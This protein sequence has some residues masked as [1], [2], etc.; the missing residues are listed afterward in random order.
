MLGRSSL[1]KIS[2]SATV[3]DILSRLLYTKFL[4]PPLL[5]LVFPSRRRPNAPFACDTALPLLRPQMR[6]RS[7]LGIT[8]C[9]A[10]GVEL[11][12]AVLPIAPCCLLHPQPP[13]VAPPASRLLYLVQHTDVHVQHCCWS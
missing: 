13:S 7:P 3:G 10:E 1:C 4:A 2:S 8:A 5:G 11:V 12:A 9:L 6:R